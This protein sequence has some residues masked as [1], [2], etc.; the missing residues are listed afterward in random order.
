MCFASD[1]VNNGNCLVRTSVNRAINYFFFF[2]RTKT[3]IKLI[4][5]HVFYSDPSSTN[6]QQAMRL[7]NEVAG[8]LLPI[9]FSRA[10]LGE[11]ESWSAPTHP[12][13]S[14]RHSQ[15]CT[16]SFMF[17]YFIFFF[18]SPLKTFAHRQQEKAGK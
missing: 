12:H 18:D 3:E 17:A 4:K 2:R 15:F 1:T 16:V 7:L 10:V 14:L 13:D 6:F 5:V 9:S 11:R 8:F